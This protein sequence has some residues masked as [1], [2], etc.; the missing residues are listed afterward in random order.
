MSDAQQ[1]LS[2]GIPK[3]SGLINGSAVLPRVDCSTNPFAFVYPGYLKT[4]VTGSLTANTLATVLNLSGRG[5]ISFLGCSNVAAAAR[6]H[7]FKVTLDGVVVFDATSVSVNADT[8]YFPAIGQ[9]APINLAGGNFAYIQEPIYFDKSLLVEYASNL[10]EVG[11]TYIA[12]R[13]YPR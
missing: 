10:T 11:Q 3:P 9:I 8:V 7:R 4:P 13:Y 6:S 2:G 12:Y 5:V 1:F